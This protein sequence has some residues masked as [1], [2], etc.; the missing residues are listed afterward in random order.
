MAKSTRLNFQL[1]SWGTRCRFA[2]W[3]LYVN[4]WSAYIFIQL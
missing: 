1:L 2:Q 4:C 3:P